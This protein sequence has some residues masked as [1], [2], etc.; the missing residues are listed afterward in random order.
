MSGYKV[1]SPAV[2]VDGMVSIVNSS[3]TALNDTDVFT[4]EWEDVSAYNSLTV[5][6]KTD[7][8][9]TYS[10]QFSPDGTNQDSTLTRY[11]RTNQIEAPH[12]FTITRKYARVV[13]T[14]D[15]GS[16]QTYFRLQTILGD[17]GELNA[18]AD[19]TLAQDFDATVV[20][21]TDFKYE[22]AEGLRQ[23]YTTWNKWGY[24]PDID[25]GTETVWSVGG[26][27]TPLSS[28]GTLEV[29]SS[30]ANDDGDPAGTGTQ[31]IIIYG[32]DANYG[33]QTE[34]VT[35]NGTTAVTTTNSW[36]GINRA[37]IYLSGSGGINAGDIS[38]T[39][40]TGGS[41]QAEIPAG[42]GS[43]QHAFFFVPAGHVGLMDWL[44]VNAVKTSGGNSPILTTKVWV[45]SLVS[46]SKYEVFRD[47]LDVGLSNHT[48]VRPSQ[49][50]V[51]GEKS[52]VE[53]QVTTDKADTVV[54]TRFSMIV[55]RLAAT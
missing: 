42:E 36:L 20:R 9:G 12:R 8:N 33:E 40:T 52:L 45:T 50:F 6:V 55:A 11:Y 53:V 18:P 37:A 14:N 46:G 15:S 10:I 16:N 22:V 27:F 7:Q 49:P 30:S 41:D 24:N 48:D 44:W 28:A 2:S 51:V 25:V 13:F 34:V 1:T 47:N 26:T 21:P 38:I 54:S 17:Q 23:G 39:A 43:T 3:T 4:G 19:S 32:V 29:V 5:A 31:S 35:M